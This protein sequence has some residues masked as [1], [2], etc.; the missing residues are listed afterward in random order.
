MRQTLAKMLV[1]ALLAGL[2]CSAATAKTRPDCT[3]FNNND[4]L[5]SHN[6][7]WCQALA[8]KEKYMEAGFVD[9]VQGSSGRAR[10]VSS[11]LTSRFS[12]GW[13]GS[14]ASNVGGTVTIGELRGR[15]RLRL[16]RTDNTL[17]YGRDIKI[18]GTA[19][20]GEGR[21]EI[22]S[23]VDVDLWTQ[24]A[25]LVDRPVRGQEPPEDGLILKGYTKTE[26]TPGT[27]QKFSASLIPIG[28]D[29]FLLLKAPDGTAKDIRLAFDKP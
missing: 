24:A 13:L 29:F 1:P 2:A 4:Q 26:V 20:S 11:Q 3:D 27:D 7:Q 22:Y 18:T 5:E 21:L 15:F 6:R 17:Y 19:R 28:G 16:A 8:F 9:S 23:Y 10:N 25:V 14:G 12:L